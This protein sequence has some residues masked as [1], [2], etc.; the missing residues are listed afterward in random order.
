[1]G[2]H[3]RIRIQIWNPHVYSFQELCSDTTISNH[4]L[5]YDN[6]SEHQ[7]GPK[8]FPAGVVGTSNIYPPTARPQ[9]PPLVPSSNRSRN[10]KLL[11]TQRARPTFV[12]HQFNLSRR[13]PNISTQA[14]LWRHVRRAYGSGCG[15]ACM[16]RLHCHR[17]A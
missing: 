5:R 10:N 16:E 15:W 11:T 1:M 4:I 3:F 2:G 6:V 13:I 17:K 12:R 8:V 14:S 9:F 7:N